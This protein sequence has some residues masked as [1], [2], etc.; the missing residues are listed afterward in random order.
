MTKSVLIALAV[1]AL[2]GAIVMLLFNPFSRTTSA[3]SAPVR[4]V[5][6]PE[7]EW[8]DYQGG[9]CGIEYGGQLKEV[10]RN[11]SVVKVEYTS[12]HGYSKGTPCDG[13]EVFDI[14]VQ[15]FDTMTAA[16]EAKK[17]FYVQNQRSVEDLRAHPV[18]NPRTRITFELGWVDLEPIDARGDHCVVADGGLVTEIGS[19]GTRLLVEY[20]PSAVTNT[21]GTLCDIG[22]TFFVDADEFDSM[23]TRYQVKIE[24]VT[25]NHAVV[26]T[27]LAHPVANP[28]VRKVADWQWVELEPRMLDYDVC[29]LEA[30]GVLTEIGTH[31]NQVLVRY[32]APDAFNIGTPCDG[33]EVFFIDA[34]QF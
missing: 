32:A 10:A 33:G 20:Q 3:S 30:G 4:T 27:L 22:A 34:Q 17:E 23:S 24:A 15:K 14:D 29:G 28:R 18:A 9:T 21:A 6:V 12:P 13:G 19:A 31:E 16:Y 26:N 7:W 8:V 11:D 25:A 2:I 1:V 5:T